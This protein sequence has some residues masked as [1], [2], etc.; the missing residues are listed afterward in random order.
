MERMVRMLGL[1]GDLL[2]RSGVEETHQAGL[3]RAI[4]LE[5]EAALVG[6]GRGRGGAGA[7]GG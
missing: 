3:A 4:V 6:G 2:G 7:A 1:D 5:V